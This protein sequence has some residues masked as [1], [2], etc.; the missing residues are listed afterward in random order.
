MN[1]LKIFQ[2][3]Q[4]SKQLVEQW[5]PNDVPFS[6]QPPTNDKVAR[7]ERLGLGAKVQ[8]QKHQLNNHQKTK[9]EKKLEKLI[10]SQMPPKVEIKY[11]NARPQKQQND[12]ADDEPSKVRANEP[13][14]RKTENYLDLFLNKKKQKK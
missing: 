6:H 4:E 2:R 9:S 1:Q 13:V 12:D 10:H 11:K 14:K 5:I 7:P 8:Q 3:I